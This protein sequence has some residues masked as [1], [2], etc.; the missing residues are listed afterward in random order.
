MF[1]PQEAFILNKFAQGLLTVE[2]LL[3]D[4]EIKSLAD[5]RQ[6]LRLILGMIQQSKPD[7]NDIIPT[8]EASQLRPTFTPCVLL[9]KGV[10]THH[11]E[12]IVS[13]PE[14]EQKKAF[15]LLIHLFKIAY[16]RRFEVEK[17]HT[18]KWWYWDFSDEEN[19]KRMAEGNIW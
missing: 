11:L 8:I 9:G 18:Y 17:N 10:R 12:K 15:V 5:K 14:N 2:E 3:V 7:E 13:L 6:H 19:V 1:S 16:L 4:F